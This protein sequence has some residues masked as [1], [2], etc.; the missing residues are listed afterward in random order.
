MLRLV[1]L[2]RTDVSEKRSASIILFL[3]SVGRLLVTANV[4]PSTPIL[5]TLMMEAL[6]SQKRR[7]LQEPCGVLSQK[8]ALFIVTVVE[9]SNLTN[10]DKSLHYPLTCISFKTHRFG[11]GIP[12]PSLDGIYSLWPSR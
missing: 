5:L 1:A 4:V 11:D 7:F 3:C 2:V 10:C 8:M 12:S 6:R 9:T